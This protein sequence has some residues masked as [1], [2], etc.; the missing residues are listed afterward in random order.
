[1]YKSRVL[2]TVNSVCPVYEA[3]D[4]DPLSAARGSIPPVCKYTNDESFLFYTS[5]MN[6]IFSARSEDALGQ[7]SDVHISQCSA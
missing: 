2:Y 5:H 4:I 6:L 3:C 7:V 1:M